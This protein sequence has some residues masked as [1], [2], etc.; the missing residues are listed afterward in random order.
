MARVIY[1]Y[2]VGATVGFMVGA[3]YVYD[4]HIQDKEKLWSKH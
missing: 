3:R 2:L 4:Y 1:A